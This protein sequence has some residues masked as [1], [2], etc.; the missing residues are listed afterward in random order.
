[1]KIWNLRTWITPYS[2]FLS[3]YTFFNGVEVIVKFVPLVL[4]MAQVAERHIDTRKSLQTNLK[5]YLYLPNIVWMLLREISVHKQV[6]KCA[7]A[8]CCI[9]GT[10]GTN[11]P[12][13][14]YSVNITFSTCKFSGGRILLRQKRDIINLNFIEYYIIKVWQ[15]Q[16]PSNEMRNNW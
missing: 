9:S 4:L 13:S 2:N 15:D 11:S 3:I 5:Y 1:M 16:L 12:L 7:S 14:T 10:S 8:T 6:W